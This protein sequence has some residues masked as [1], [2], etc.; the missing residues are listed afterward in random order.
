MKRIPLVL[1]WS[2]GKDSTLA[3]EAL[4][5]GAQYEVVALLTTVN[6]AY[7]RISM[8][9]VR[10]TLLDKQAAA[11]DLPLDKVCLPEKA[12]NQT[13]AAAMGAQLETYR[14]RGIGCV[15][16]GDI[17]LEDIRAYRE[18]QMAAVDMQCTFPLWRRSTHE[19]AERFIAHDFG[20]TLT[21]VDTEAISGD[22]A[23]REFDAALLRELPSSC[24]PCGENGE[25]HTF[26]H[27]GPLFREPIAV[28]TGERVLRDGRFNFCDLVPA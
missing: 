13:Y 9:G 28:C 5:A 19:L 18:R 21:C 2:G 1:S 26:V 25:F 20:A 15:A 6:S 14:G 4:T 11:L 17:F 7:R 3:L 27:R 8:H 10:E 22:F 24:D 12:D 16:F 23:G